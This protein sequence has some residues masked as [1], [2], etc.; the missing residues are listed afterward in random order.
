MYDRVYLDI[1]QASRKRIKELEDTL[2]YQYID[3]SEYRDAE[4][5]LGSHELLVNEI[6]SK[7][8]RSHQHKY[9]KEELTMMIKDIITKEGY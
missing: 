4:I 5:L 9:T 8:Y 2:Q 7:V 3:D 1:Q 6:Y